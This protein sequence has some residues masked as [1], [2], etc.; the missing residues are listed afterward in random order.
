MI[1]Q[2]N[3]VNRTFHQNKTKFIVQKENF[4]LRGKLTYADEQI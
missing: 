2:K 3:E 4:L 1:E